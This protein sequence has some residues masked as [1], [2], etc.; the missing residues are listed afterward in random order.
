MKRRDFITLLGGSAARRLGGRVAAGSARAAADDAGDRV[1]R[2][3]IQLTCMQI[4]CTHTAV[5]A[6]AGCP[7]SLGRMR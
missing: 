7:R 2:Q 4:V 3:R 5:R 1:S 6:A